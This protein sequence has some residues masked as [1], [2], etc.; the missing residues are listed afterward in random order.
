MTTTVAFVLTAAEAHA[1]GYYGTFTAEPLQPDKELLGIDKPVSLAAGSDLRTLFSEIKK[2]GCKNALIVSHGSKDGLLIH[3]VSGA[4]T[5]LSADAAD[6][7]NKLIDGTTS[8]DTAEK[9]LSLEA[10]DLKALQKQ[11]EDVRKQGIDKLVLRACNVGLNEGALAAFRKLFGSRSICA[12]NV[13]DTFGVFSAKVASDSK[14]FERFAQKNGLTIDGSPPNRFAWKTDI[15]PLD[16]NFNTTSIAE[17]KQGAIDW[18]A[19]RFPNSKYKGEDSFAFHG[20][21]PEGSRRPIFP[22][23]AGFRGRLVKR[24]K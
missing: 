24:P 8:R 7:M 5:E 17:S 12:P 19:L 2:S 23:D 14:F 11:I 22:L 9:Q 13:R 21:V 1:A 15:K 18:A 6:V 20:L 3:L 10:K 16:I 4:A